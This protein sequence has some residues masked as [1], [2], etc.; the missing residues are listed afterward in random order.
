MQQSDI[1]GVILR[2]S[3]LYDRDRTRRPRPSIHPGRRA[4]QLQVFNGYFMGSTFNN[5]T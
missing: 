3:S 1:L 5:D 4:V 2:Q